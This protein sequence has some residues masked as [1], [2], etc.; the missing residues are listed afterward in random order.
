MLCVTVLQQVSLVL[1][2]FAL[3]GVH[4][5]RSTCYMIAETLLR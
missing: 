4:V 3:N 1:H 5:L 2:T